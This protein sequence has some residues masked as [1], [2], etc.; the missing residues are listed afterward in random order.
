MTAY[1][2]GLVT[3]LVGCYASWSGNCGI[4]G[5]RI[6][7]VWV[8]GGTIGPLMIAVMNED[9]RIVKKDAEKVKIDANA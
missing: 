4:E 1:D 5:G 9:G 8:P 6:V 7:A 3:S 2:G